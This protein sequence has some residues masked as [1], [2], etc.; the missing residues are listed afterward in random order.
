MDLKTRGIISSIINNVFESQNVLETIK[1]ILETDDEVISSEDLAL[2]YFLGSLMKI[3]ANSAGIM[4]KIA[5]SNE[6]YRKTLEKIYGKKEGKIKYLEYE[7]KMY[8]PSKKD[9]VPILIEPS[10]EEIDEIRNM[11][12]PMIP[13]FR[14]K[15]RQ[16]ETLNII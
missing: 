13:R 4:H 15:I 11:L 16:E 2:G 10:K 9:S 1:W 6:Q 12:I 14:E 5:F 3:S 7:M 8:E